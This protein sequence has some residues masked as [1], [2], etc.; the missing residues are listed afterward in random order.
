[1][2][3]IYICHQYL[4]K[5]HFLAIYKCAEQNGF[6]VKDY[7]VL[8]N[9]HII[10]R[11]GKQILYEHKLAS[12]IQECVFSLRKIQK[13]KKLEDK[14]IIVGLAPYDYLMNKY[15]EIFKKNKSIYFTSWQFWDGSD[16]PR[17]SIE[18]KDKFEELLRNSFY[19]AACVSQVT[20]KQVN[21]FIPKT[22]VVNHSIPIAEYKKKEVG[23]IQENRYLFLG[24]LAP[25]KNI[26]YILEYM[27][28]NPNEKIEIDIAGQGALLED[29]KNAEGVDARIHY[30]GLW[31]KEEIKERLYQYKFLLLPSKEEPFGIVLLE[32]LAA[33]VPSIV[34]TALGPDEI[35]EDGKTGL[36]FNLDDE[37]K[38]FEEAMRR[39]QSIEED[40]Y[41]AMITNCL[42]ASEQ[43]SEEAVFKKWKTIL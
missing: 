5:S 3:E 14:I 17:G 29:V 32:A 8:G 36:K 24:R 16:F 6:V 21:T 40:A 12:A 39:A 20:E 11:M 23:N 15:A 28:N 13:L 27:K 9:K 19:A 34:S 1:M 26:G 37:Y 22:A 7:I 38:G 30:L 2:K 18:N 43:Y 41:S 35:I 10:N 42:I 4:D 33:G 25:A 31:S